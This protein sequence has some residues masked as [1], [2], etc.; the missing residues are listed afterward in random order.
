MN[1]LLSTSLASKAEVACLLLT[2]VALLGAAVARRWP[3]PGRGLALGAVGLAVALALA[4]GVLRDLSVT[5]YRAEVPAT[6]LAGVLGR[7]H[8]DAMRIVWWGSGLAA[9]V[10]LALPR[11]RLADRRWPVAGV[12]GLALTLIAGVLTPQETLL[13]AVVGAI[14]LAHARREGPSAWAAGLLGL[15]VLAGADGRLYHDLALFQVEDVARWGWDLAARGVA[16]AAALAWWAQALLPERRIRAG[17][18]LGAAL[19]VLVAGRQVALSHGPSTEL[20]RFVGQVPT[21]PVR[22]AYRVPHGCLV[23]REGDGLAVRAL[24]RPWQA[25]SC[26]AR[27]SFVRDR[28]NTPPLLALGADEPTT[29]MTGWYPG[30]GEVRLLV[31]LEGT[32]MPAWRLVGEPF[33]VWP[34]PVE[35]RFVELAGRPGPNAVLLAGGVLRGAAGSELESSRVDGDLGAALLELVGDRPRVDFLIAPSDAPTVGDL[36]DVCLK[37]RTARPTGLR[38]VI[39]EGD[40]TGF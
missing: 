20:L 6:H 33:Q 36:L 1:E 5:A 19:A 17:I 39:A 23:T 34:G 35:G 40:W 29:S 38:C 16:S 24:D 31:E 14:W 15:S 32:G 25:W 26:P 7:R 11:T 22:T 12:V 10:A 27:G 2:V 9:L 4:S 37:A 3:R 30:P 21:W 28:R 18:G 13:T 8:A